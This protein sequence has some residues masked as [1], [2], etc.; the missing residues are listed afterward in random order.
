VLVAIS[1]SGRS[2]TVL[3]A[4]RLARRAGATVVLITNFPVSPLA[5]QADVK[6]LTAAFSK[7][8]TGE[9]ISRR[10]AELCIIE[11]LSLTC[12]IRKGYAA[13]EKLNRSNEAVFVYKV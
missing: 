7:N 10:V 13:L 2:T 4:M 8:I 5:K 12:F 6:L 3:E 1:H 11:S 9:M